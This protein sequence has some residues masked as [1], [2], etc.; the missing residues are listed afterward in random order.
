MCVCG[1]FFGASRLVRWLISCWEEGE[2]TA[3]TP[4]K[5]FAFSGKWI[6]KTTLRLLRSP[7]VSWRGR[8]Y[9]FSLFRTPSLFGK[10]V[11]RGLL[12]AGKSVC[13]CSLRIDGGRAGVWRSGSCS[14]NEPPSFKTKPKKKTRRDRH[15]TVWDTTGLNCSCANLCWEFKK[16]QTPMTLICS[17]VQTHKHLVTYII[18]FLILPTIEPVTIILIVYYITLTSNTVPMQSYDFFLVFHGCQDDFR[19][20]NNNRTVTLI[21]RVHF[22]SR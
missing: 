8:G 19:L 20:K 13:V 14:F 6:V 10:V 2:R 4:C 22:D 9:R 12:T 16:K 1:C 15:G 5:R 21:P 7:G 11:G 18:L 17:A 3:V